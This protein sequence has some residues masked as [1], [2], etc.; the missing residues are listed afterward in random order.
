MICSSSCT[1]SHHKVYISAA[2]SPSLRRIYSRQYQQCHVRRSCSVIPRRPCPFL[3][4]N[5][6]T[7]RRWLLYL[8]IGQN[9]RACCPITRRS[10]LSINAICQTAITPTSSFSHANTYVTSYLPLY[11]WLSNTGMCRIT[12]FRSMTDRIYDGGPIIL[13]YIIL[14]YI[15]LYYIILYYIILL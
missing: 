11:V 4:G 15:I 6:K 2:Q 5:T 7:R 14:Y 10:L 9:T 12:T 1:F 3:S 13:Y 8:T